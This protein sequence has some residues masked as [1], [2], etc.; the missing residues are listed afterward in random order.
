MLASLK[1][2]IYPK[3]K[4]E[5]LLNRRLSS[6]RVYNSSRNFKIN[7]CKNEHTIT[8][9]VSAFYEEGSSQLQPFIG[10]HLKLDVYSILFP[11]DPGGIIVDIKSHNYH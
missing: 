1:H 5:R 2:R 7:N 3:P 11:S 9:V 10:H 4:Q 6:C 8:E